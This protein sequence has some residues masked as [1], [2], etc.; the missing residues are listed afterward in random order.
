[1][2]NIIMIGLLASVAWAADFSNMSTE[3]MMN[4]RGS[5]PVDDRPAF[6]QEM[7]KRMQS[8]TPEER[9]K[10]MRT[11]GMGKGM[12]M[13]SKRNCCKHIMQPT[14]EEYD[15]NNDGKITQSE[16]EEAR[17]KRMSQKAKE[18]KMLRNAGKAPA[19]SDMDK[20]NDG[21]LN[22]EEFQIHQTEQMKKC[23]GN[24]PSTGMGQRKSMMR[25]ASSFAEI[26]TNKDGVISQEEFNVHQTQR[27]KNRGNCPSGNCP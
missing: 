17:A 10:Y 21:A 5:V 27:M 4:M 25:N 13:T 23:T 22:K 16:L 1:M 18:G 2:K 11:N 8:M 12:G 7:Q 3:E 26:D 6:Q 9:Q 15:L 14:F 20:N 19:F 24:C